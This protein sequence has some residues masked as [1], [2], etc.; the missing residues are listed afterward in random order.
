MRFGIEFGFICLCDC[1][2][3][4][5]LN[6]FLLDMGTK[7]DPFLGCSDS[8]FPNLFDPVPQGSFLKVLCLILVH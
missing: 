4:D 1:F 5:L 7:N 2:V 3:D 6:E 8:H